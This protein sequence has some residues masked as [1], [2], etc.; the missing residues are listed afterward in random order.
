MTDSK[1]NLLHAFN[2][3]KLTILITYIYYSKNNFRTFAF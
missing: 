2:K 1:I 3:L